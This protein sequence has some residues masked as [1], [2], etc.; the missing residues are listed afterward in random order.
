M[1]DWVV[2]V[3]KYFGFEG[4]LANL[5]VNNDL[6][7]TFKPSA[8]KRAV[9]RMS[10]EIEK[11]LQKH[12]SLDIQIIDQESRVIKVVHELGDHIN[13]AK[14]LAKYEIQLPLGYPAIPGICYLSKQSL[15]SLHR[16]RQINKHLS[17]IAAE[18]ARKTM[19]SLEKLTDCI[20]SLANP[21]HI[22]HPAKAQEEDKKEED[23]SSIITPN[24]HCDTSALAGI[25]P[26]PRFCGAIFSGDWLVT[27]YQSR[28][29]HK[30][31][32]AL[33]KITSPE[34][35]SS[36]IFFSSINRRNFEIQRNLLAWPSHMKQSLEALVVCISSIIER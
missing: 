34:D 1:T 2:L 24:N 7:E 35:L 31:Y 17:D 15:V 19:L 36:G 22:T 8:S 25:V 29:I 27:F 20:V 33:Q 28:S 18:C 14:I 13:G 23:I 5:L 32:T 10:D 12:P 4:S 9:Y 16:R 6:T 21:L 26:F 30:Q 3:R 11:A